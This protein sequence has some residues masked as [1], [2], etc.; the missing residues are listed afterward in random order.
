M[1]NK[2]I[3]SICVLGGMLL[4]ALLPTGSAHAGL[5]TTLNVTV[6]ET[7]GGLTHY[8]YDLTNLATSDENVATLIIGVDGNAALT[9]IAGPAGWDVSYTTGD[10]SVGWGSPDPTID[11]PPGQSTSFFLDSPLGP[12]PQD[13]L[14]LGSN[15]GG[16]DG[17]I[18]APS[19]SAVP[20]PSALMLLAIAG[21]FCLA[22]L[23][24]RQAGGLRGVRH[25]VGA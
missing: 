19:V 16:V 18:P 21:V 3:K 12:G 24:L 10:T 5:M 9:S 13:Y 4:A 1:I 22:H 11:L 17:V 14:I 6:A 15:F 23:V 7:S 2:A 20:E 8:E 25:Y